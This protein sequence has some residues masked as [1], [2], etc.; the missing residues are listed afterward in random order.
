MTHIKK[1]DIMFLLKRYNVLYNSKE[2]RDA[3]VYNFRKY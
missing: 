1:C 2:K 3:Y